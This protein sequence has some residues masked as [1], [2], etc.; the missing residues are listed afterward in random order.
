MLDLSELFEKHSDEFLCF[1]KVE[2]K[3]SNYMD[4]HAYLLLEQICGPGHKMIAGARH[5]EVFL[6]ANVETLAEKA[7]EEQIV[8]LIRCG[9]RY[10]EGGLVMF[11]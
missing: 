8:E 2:N 10:D 9:I 4:I 6:D 3:R 1:E 7:T 11:A 5:D